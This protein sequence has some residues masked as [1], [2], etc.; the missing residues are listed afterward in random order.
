MLG[1]HHHGGTEGKLPISQLHPCGRI[2]QA[3]KFRLCHHSVP[4]LD[5]VELH[6]LA[7][8]D[9]HPGIGVVARFAVFQL[10][11]LRDLLTGV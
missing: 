8:S 7:L 3:S 1:D 5:S 10:L 2:L 9:V 4:Q 6:L 11:A